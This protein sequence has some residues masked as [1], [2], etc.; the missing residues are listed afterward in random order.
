MWDNSTLS[1]NNPLPRTAYKGTGMQSSQGLLPLRT[2]P[3]PLVLASSPGPPKP[4]L[5]LSLI[6]IFTSF[7]GLWSL[8]NWSSGWR[9]GPAV[10][11][12]AH[13]PSAGRRPTEPPLPHLR[14][15]AA[16][17]SSTVPGIS[18]GASPFGGPGVSC[19]G[20]LFE[21]AVARP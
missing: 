11:A 4:S 15:G 2:L 14:P 10:F 12:M 9:E 1:Q 8:I 21:P 18:S 6:I 3:R 13:L 7:T 17:S 16:S 20:P 5:V 19:T